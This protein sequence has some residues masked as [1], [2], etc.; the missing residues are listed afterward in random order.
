MPAA[1]PSPLR[2]PGGKAAL[3]GL[4]ADL[5]RVNDA[6]DGTYVEPYCGGAGAALTLLMGE[7]VRYIVLNDADPAVY[8]FWWAALRQSELLTKLLRDTPVTIEEWYRQRDIYR[9]KG[10]F[11]R[12][13]IAFA[14]LYLNRCNRSGII[15]DGGP[16]GGVR[17]DGKWR[18]DARF[19]RPQLIRRLERLSLYRDRIAVYS[20]DAVDF[21]RKVV[22]PR[23]D[24]RRT[25]VYLDPP[26]YGKGRDLYANYYAP[27]DHAALAAYL[28]YEAH[29]R[30]VLSYD[31]VPEI[32]ELYSGMEQF[33]VRVSYSAHTRRFGR[34]LIVCSDSL[35]FPKDHV[36]AG[37]R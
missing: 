25:V 7:H 36:S 12:V 11:S 9:R 24:L 26:Y 14:T 17:Q 10:R 2:Y 4:M 18:L 33:H 8:N 34:E 16:I 32:R 28:K 23:Q 31:D 3:A 13:E 15:V 22:R 20:M 37:F 19:N 5:I 6:C 27:E 21:L 30:W 29:F 35:R 1:P